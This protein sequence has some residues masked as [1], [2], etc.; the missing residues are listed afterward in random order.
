MELEL[1]KMHTRLS[2]WNYSREAKAKTWIWGNILIDTV[3]SCY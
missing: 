1:Q 3:Q 2:E